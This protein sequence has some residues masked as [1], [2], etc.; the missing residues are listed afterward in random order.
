ML[1]HKSQLKSKTAEKI[2]QEC[3]ISPAYTKT[4]EGVNT[5]Q[6][7]PGGKHKIRQRVYLETQY[8]QEHVQQSNF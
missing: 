6:K 5:L 4:Q 8:S 7:Q 1:S 2:M 3:Q